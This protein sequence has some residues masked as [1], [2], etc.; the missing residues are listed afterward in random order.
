MKFIFLCNSFPGVSLSLFE[1]DNDL[2][3]GAKTR[4]T[5]V[6]KQIFRSD[7]GHFD[8]IVSKFAKETLSEY[9]TEAVALGKKQLH[10]MT[11]TE[12]VEW[13]S[14][15]DGMSEWSTC[16]TKDLHN[17]Y[18]KDVCTSDEFYLNKKKFHK[19]VNLWG[20]IMYGQP[21]VILIT[22]DV[23]YFQFNVNPDRL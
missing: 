22:D 13:A 20:L 14:N 16:K 15:Q 19:W 7:L 17:G 3:L 23:E 12:F 10:S 11:S 18:L 6:E 8:D 5:N 9:Y 21:P 1:K 4:L 2:F